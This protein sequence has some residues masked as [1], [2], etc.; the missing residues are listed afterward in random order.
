MFLVAQRGSVAEINHA[1]C[2]ALKQQSLIL[3]PG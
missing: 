2:E 1:T 3:V